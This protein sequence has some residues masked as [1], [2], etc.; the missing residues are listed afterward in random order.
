MMHMKKNTD[1]TLTYESAW[2]E[3]QVIVAELQSGQTSIDQLSA[4]IERAS[5]LVQFCRE[6]LRATENSL[7]RL[8]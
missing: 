4:K 6:K 2:S 1:E 7:S 5:V 3:L 8:G